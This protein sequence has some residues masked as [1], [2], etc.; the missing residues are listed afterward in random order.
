MKTLLFGMLALLSLGAQ[1]KKEIEGDHFIL[2]GKI[3]EIDVFKDGAVEASNVNVIIYQDQEIYVSFFG[4][5]NGSY[6]FV[7]PVGHEYEVWFGGKAYVNKKV[8]VDARKMPQ[9]KIGYE[10]NID[11][12]LFKPI[13]NAEFP[14]LVDHYVKVRWDSE[15]RELTPDVEY[16]EFKARELEKALKKIK[17]THGGY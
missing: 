5:E 3:Y 7:L 12:G 9:R 17:K 14:L 16:T 10:C 1:A 13:E 11:M 8:Y 15:Y 4:K 2:Q 6:E